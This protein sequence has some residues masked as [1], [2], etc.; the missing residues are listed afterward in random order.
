MTDG[1]ASSTQQPLTI[2]EACPVASRRCLELLEDR[3]HNSYRSPNYDEDNDA[4]SLNVSRYHVTRYLACFR[5][6]NA[7]ENIHAVCSR[8]EGSQL[9][10]FSM[11]TL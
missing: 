10:L 6:W 9:I 5:N 3:S 11:V 7:D 8:R 2:N 4:P 1:G